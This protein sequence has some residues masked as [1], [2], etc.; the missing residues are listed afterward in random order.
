VSIDGVAL[1]FTAAAA[2]Y[3][4]RCVFGLAPA[5][6]CSRPDLNEALK[7]GSLRRVGRSF[8]G[9]HAQFARRRGKWRSQTVLLVG[10]GLMLQSFAKL[11]RDRPGLSHR[12]RPDGGTGFFPYPVFTTLGA[13]D[14]HSPASA[15]E[16][17]ARTRPATPWRAISGRGVSLL[18]RRQ[19]S[20]DSVVHDLW[21]AAVFRN[22][23]GPPPSTTRSL[24]N[25]SALSE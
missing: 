8:G 22:R 16:G 20:A 3:D 10:A 13:P 4:R 2:L 18:P 21:P 7:E 6:Q 15:L 5:W 9:T 23:S 14:S 1:C 12:A 25:T 11:A 17:I 19:S 24:P